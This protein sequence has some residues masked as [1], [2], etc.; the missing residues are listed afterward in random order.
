[1]WDALAEDEKGNRRW[2]AVGSA[3]VADFSH[4]HHFD[5]D[6]ALDAHGTTLASTAI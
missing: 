1:V 3:R 4:S 2:R 6:L 5:L